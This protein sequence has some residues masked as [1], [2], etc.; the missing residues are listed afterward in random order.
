MVLAIT[1]VPCVIF[2]K[3]FRFLG[4]FKAFLESERYVFIFLIGTLGIY[5]WLIVMILVV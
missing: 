1:A 2:L 4:E 5:H 3:L